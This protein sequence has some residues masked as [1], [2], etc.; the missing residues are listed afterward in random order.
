MTQLTVSEKNKITELPVNYQPFIVAKF[1]TQ[2]K[3]MLDRDLYFACFDMIGLAL[4]SNGNK[5]G[6]DKSVQEFLSKELAKDL[7]QP[8]FHLM[9]IDEI[10]MA[11]NLGVRLEYGQFFGINITTI[12]FWIKS[13]ISDKN[14]ELAISEYNRKLSELHTSDK[15][16][17]FTKEYLIKV[18]NSALEDYK[19][20]GSMPIIPHAIYDTIKEVKGLDTLILKEDWNFIKAEAKESYERKMNPKKKKSVAEML[21]YGITYE[22]EVKRV[23]LKYYFE[24]SKNESK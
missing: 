20:D 1:G 17:V 19:R 4:A 23:A 22:F 5:D 18:A 13:F 8:K 14:R 16:V 7:R 6:S 3:S 10:K 21:D 15:P 2:I 24:R 9:S 12:H 11:L